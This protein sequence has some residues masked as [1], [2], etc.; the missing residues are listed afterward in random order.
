MRLVSVTLTN[1]RRFTSPVTV[2]GFGPGLNVLA[3]PNEQ[4]KSTLFDALQAVFF[5]PHRTAGKEIKALRPH[6]GG[7]PEVCVEVETPEGAFAITKRWL[8][9]PMAEVRQ[10]ARLVAQADEA[11]AW[12]ARLMRG[13]GAGGP[14]GLL[15]VRQ[16][17]AG[18][19]PEGKAQG[20]R[21]AEMRR[22]LMSSVAGEVEALTGGRRMDAA[23]ARARAEL[24][25]QVTA[26]GPRA[27]G[28]LKAAEDE[29]TAL[30]A[31]RADLTA[32]AEALHAALD[33]R[34]AVLRDLAVLE[35]PGEAADRAARL[36]EADAADRAAARQ[37]EQLEGARLAL[38]LAEGTS[39]PLDD[40]SGRLHRGDGAHPGLEPEL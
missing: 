22:D 34:R 31:A 3:A 8:A 1:L 25:V 20:D 15:W 12:I 28:P 32:R 16:G 33:R 18:L 21:A 38:R 27:G 9:R 30:T 6:A 10:G 13:D 17:Q 19:E 24:E 26:R 5:Q 35:D 36:A 2:R 11:E 14:A 37:A 4:G 39:R 40:D 29:V 23:M 7:A